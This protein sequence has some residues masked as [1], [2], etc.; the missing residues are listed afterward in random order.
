MRQTCTR[1]GLATV[2]EQVTAF[3]IAKQS[4]GP[5]KPLE[6]WEAEDRSGWYRFDTPG[7]TIYAAEDRET[8]FLE[9][10]SWAR[11]TAGFDAYLRKSAGFFQEPVENIRAEV[12]EQWSRNSGMVPG[13]IPANWREGRLVYT[14]EFEPGR[15]VDAAHAETI[16]AV[17]KALRADLPVLGVTETLT[18][19][20]ITSGHRELTTL[21]AAWIRD[22]VLDDGTYPLGIR[23][24]SKHG[25][26]GTGPG[27][28]WAFWL[29][30][31]DVG[32]ADDPVT[33]VSAQE[34]SLTD[35]AYP[36]ALDRHGIQSR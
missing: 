19:S 6:R 12:E 30:R 28:C 10:L 1:T 18:L 25:A 4:Y 21:M 29:R 34:I 16:T 8:A 32:L 7:R 35:P 22:Q 26:A 31:A 36:G 13:W 15:W 23:F 2:R 17:D 11:M 20:E 5:L 33:I 27:Y 24:P 14:L 9:A 3:R